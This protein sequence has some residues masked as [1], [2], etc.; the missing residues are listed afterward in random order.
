MRC[1]FCGD[2]LQSIN[3]KLISPLGEKCLGNPAGK[4]IGLTD[5]VCCVYCGDETKTQNG[6][7]ATKLGLC[8]LSS[9]T[10]MHCLQ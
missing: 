3:Q 6:K 10:G 9:P 2:K 4:H 7:L 5:S 1:R 8:C